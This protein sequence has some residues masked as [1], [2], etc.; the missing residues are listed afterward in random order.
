MAGQVEDVQVGDQIRAGSRPRF[1]IREWKTNL[2]PSFVFDRRAVVRD[3]QAAAARA[4]G[5]QATDTTAAATRSRLIRRASPKAREPRPADDRR[6]PQTHD[7][8][9]GDR[10]QERSRLQGWPSVRSS[11]RMLARGSGFDSQ[12]EIARPA[13]LGIR[14][15]LCG[16]TAPAARG[17][18][19]RADAV[20]GGENADQDASEARKTASIVPTSAPVPSAS[21]TRP[22][23]RPRKQHVRIGDQEPR[24]RARAPRAASRPVISSGRQDQHEALEG[25]ALALAAERVR[26]ASRASSAP[27]RCHLKREV[28]ASRARGS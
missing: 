2:W 13:L 18:R 4:A 7:A 24:A 15:K 16:R 23:P 14:R 17:G 22:T 20:G 26:R 10:S 8:M 9:T 5:T 28:T 21:P 19:R 11:P 25:A 1:R 12:Q 27:R 3:G 6:A